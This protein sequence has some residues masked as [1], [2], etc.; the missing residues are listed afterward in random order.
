[1]CYPW[2]NF[3]PP[4]YIE[5]PSYLIA[6]ILWIICFYLECNR[7]SV[8]FVFTHFNTDNGVGISSSPYIFLVGLLMAQYS[9]SEYDASAH[10]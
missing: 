10:M 2:W 3:A 6:I 1:Y 5:H 8:K 4:R 9:L 7:A